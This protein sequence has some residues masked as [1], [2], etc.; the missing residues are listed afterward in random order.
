MI[1]HRPRRNRKSNTIRAMVQETQVLNSD[2]I[3][4]LF[5]LQCNASFYFGLYYKKKKKKI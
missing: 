5:F 4:P 2:L 3:F 1:T